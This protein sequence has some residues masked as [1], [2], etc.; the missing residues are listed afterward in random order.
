MRSPAAGARPDRVSALPRPQTPEPAPEPRGCVWVLLGDKAGDNAQAVALAQAL[1]LPFETRT[2]RYNALRLLWNGW[3]G[4]GLTSVSASRSEAI[5]PP[6]PDLVIAVGRRSVPVARFIRRASGDRTKL[7]Q[8]GRPRAPARFFDLVLTTP[9]Y[10]FARAANVIEMPLPFGMGAGPAAT[11]AGGD[12]SDLAALPRPRLAV[13]VGGPS[14]YYRM[15]AAA[16]AGL[17]RRV[18]ALARRL[19]GSLLLVTS[20]RTPDAA[21]ALLTEGWT[22]PGRF[23]RFGTGDNPYRRFLA[24]ADAVVVTADS[25]SMIADGLGTGKPVLVFEPPD[26]GAPAVW[27][28]R[29]DAAFGHGGP[30]SDSL[31]GRAWCWLNDQGFISAPRQLDQMVGALV[32]GGAVARLEE[33][34]ATLPAAGGGAAVLAAARGEAVRRIHALLQGKG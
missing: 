26:C 20:R 34:T 19:G 31:L 23:S 4:S 27:W 12:E 13:L 18:E 14:G 32:T 10:R 29:F 33:T 25:A 8:I 15:D 1:G 22:V 7:V 6:W 2:I 17:K 3:L 5:E 21:A 16:A 11:D 24:A 28:W 9:Q 30:R